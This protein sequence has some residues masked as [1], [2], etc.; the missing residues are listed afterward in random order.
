M[1]RRRTTSAFHRCL[2]VHHMHFAAC[3]D[4]P[5]RNRLPRTPMAKLGHFIVGVALGAMT[6]AV[7]LAWLA[8]G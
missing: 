2:A 8:G 1:I 3:R 6:A 7:V 5:R 4:S